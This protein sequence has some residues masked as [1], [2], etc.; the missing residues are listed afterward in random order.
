MMNIHTNNKGHLF[1]LLITY[2]YFEAWILLMKPDHEQPMDWE[3]ITEF[4]L[5]VI[6]GGEKV[7]VYSPTYLENSVKTLVQI[8]SNIALFKLFIFVFL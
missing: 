8:K 4:M 6:S 1:N 5:G 7:S 3:L 2:S